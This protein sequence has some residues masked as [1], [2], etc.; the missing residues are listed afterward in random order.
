MDFTFTPDQIEFRNSVRDLLLNRCPP[1][2]IR[3]ASSGGDL[4]RELWHALAD[5]GLMATTTAEDSGGLGLDER[6]LELPLEEAGYFGLPYPIVETAAV[7]MPILAG[8]VDSRSLL[9]TDL[10]GTAIP[11]C[12]DADYLLLTLHEDGLTFAAQQGLVVEARTSIDKS[13]RTG[14]VV[15][16][17]S[18]ADRIVADRALAFDRG[19]WG[20]AAVLIGLSQ[21]MLDMTTKY[22]ADRRQFGVPVGSFQAVKHHLSDAA[23]QIQFSRPVVRRA[24]WSIATGQSTRSRDVSIAKAFASETASLVSATTLQCHGAIG[25]T[26]E[27]DLQL[28]LNRSWALIRSWGDAEWHRQ[29]VGYAIGLASTATF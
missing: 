18:D 13:R 27:Y 12:L 26:E 1:S 7:A 3:D 15:R 16:G 14:Y 25:Y 28:L 19:A 9:T 23:M 11:N 2:V 24:A 6:W 21:R 4:D 10:G 20:T 5:M 8:R 22:V 29:R 17:L